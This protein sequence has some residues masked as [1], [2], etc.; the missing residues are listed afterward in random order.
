VANRIKTGGRQAGTPN[1][2]T[3]QVRE[4]LTEI[5]SKELESLGDTLA[6]LPPT[7]RINAL[8]KLV[9]FVMPKPMP[10]NE[11]EGNKDIEITLNLQGEPNKIK[12]T[13]AS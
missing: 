9:G 7:E 8:I 5:V 13:V 4:L 11:S 1:R 10:M 2:T 12:G 3:A 6:G